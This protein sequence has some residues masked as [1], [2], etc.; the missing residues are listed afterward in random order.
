MSEYTQ[1]AFT[2]ELEKI[3][4]TGPAGELAMLGMPSVVG[5]SM[6]RATPVSSKEEAEEI[7]SFMAKGKKK[8]I[9]ASIRDILG[10]TFIPGYTGYR[11]GRTAAGKAYLKK[12]KKKKKK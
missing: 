7:L 3:A 2:D 11:M 5:H 10:F 4:L 8:R 6:G 1:I 12:L 9:G